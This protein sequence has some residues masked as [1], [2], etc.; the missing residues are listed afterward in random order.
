MRIHPRGACAPDQ[1][2]GRELGLR[3]LLDLQNI[4]EEALARHP[5]IWPLSPM[6]YG[7]IS[8][9]SACHQQVLQRSL[10]CTAGELICGLQRVL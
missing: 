9:C 10:G 3:V 1:P 4:L 2:L 5:V 6:Y 7:S 8:A